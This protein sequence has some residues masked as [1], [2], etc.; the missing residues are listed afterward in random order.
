MLPEWY[1]ELA[2]AAGPS[3]VAAWSNADVVALSLAVFTVGFTLAATTSAHWLLDV[4]FAALVAGGILVTW[5]AMIVLTMAAV[6][7]ATLVSFL[8]KWLA[9]ARQARIEAE[10]DRLAAPALADIKRDF[11]K[12]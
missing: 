6:G 12:L 4:A 8:H 9:P 1:L 2:R 10:A 7:V 5:P 3:Y 11:E